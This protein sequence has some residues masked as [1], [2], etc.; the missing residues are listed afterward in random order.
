M[1]SEGITLT[2]AQRAAAEDAG[3]PL[4]VLAG[5]GTGQTRTMVHRI[6]H[7]IRERGIEPE[8][9]V[10]LTFTVKAAG[11]LRERLAEVIGP[12]QAERVNAHTIHAFGH[13]L[14]RSF[15]D[16]IGL[17]AEFELIDAAQSK[18]LLKRIV[19]DIG[20]FEDSRAEG[21]SA[22][23]E[24]LLEAFHCLGN[25]GVLP[26]RCL[27][28]AE[29]WANRPARG[30]GL[31]DALEQEADA[32][33]Q[34]RFADTARAYAVYTRECQAKGWVSFE[35]FVTLPI[36]LLTDRAAAVAMCRDN[37][38]AFIVD[39]FQDCNPGQIELLRL[40]APP[41]SQPDLCVVG[42]DDQAIYRFRGADEQAFKRFAKTWGRHEVFELKENYRS[43]PELIRVANTIIANADVRFKPDKVIEFPAGKKPTG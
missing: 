27:K 28:F 25:M 43:Q 41:A 37:Y 26:E 6:A 4:V 17:P 32:A 1:G 18:R 16:M 11:Q 24:D 30:D 42:D 9:I 7:Q 8:R 2:P 12:V 29:Q 33:R 40:L 19:L 31:F 35:D 34:K 14:V 21:L 13:K 15:G 10:A 5:P 23:A 39:E 38:R 36:R 20:L 22:I 3:G